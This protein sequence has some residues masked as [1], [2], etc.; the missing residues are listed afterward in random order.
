LHAV[1]DKI[2]APGQLVEDPV[3]AAKG[4]IGEISAA[5]VDLKLIVLCLERSVQYF[6]QSSSMQLMRLL[7]KRF[8]GRLPAIHKLQIMHAAQP[9]AVEAEERI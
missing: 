1:L 5:K 8:D 7:M 6:V 2:V 4:W 9:T 3:C